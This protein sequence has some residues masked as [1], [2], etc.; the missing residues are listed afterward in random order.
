MT[1]KSEFNADEWQTITEAPAL[2][3]MIVITAQ[4]GGTIRES[5]AMARAYVEAEKEHGG[6]SLLGEVVESPPAL[7][8]SKYKNAEQLRSE[9]LA[10]LREGVAL[11]EAKASAE[12]VDAYKRFA[13]TVAERAAAADKSGGFLGIGG[14]EISDSEGAAL[15]EIRSALAIG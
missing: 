6:H 1:T 15:G 9:G 8:A 11:L 5:V 14:K 2:A 12:E 10:A 7:D 4:R 3:G 13:M